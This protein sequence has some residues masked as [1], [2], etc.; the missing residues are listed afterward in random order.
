MKLQATGRTTGC[1]ARKLQAFH[2]LL[3]V[4]R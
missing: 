3:G 2:S 4:Q 1:M